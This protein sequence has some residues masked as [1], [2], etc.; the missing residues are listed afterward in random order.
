M[1]KRQ[2][3]TT[4]ARRRVLSASAWLL[5]PLVL[6]FVLSI[7]DGESSL[8]IS[9]RVTDRLMDDFR[10][11]DFERVIE[12]YGQL[13]EEKK[14]DPEVCYRLGYSYLCRN[15]FLKAEPFVQ[16]A[17]LAHCENI[18][19][20]P[21]PPELAER[22][23]RLKYFLPPLY[24][25]YRHDGL[26]FTVYG[27]PTDWIK[28][29][30]KEM[31]TFM[32]RSVRAFGRNAS[33]LDFYFFEKRD[34]YDRFASLLFQRKIPD[35]QQNG[36]G[37]IGVVLFCQEDGRGSPVAATNPQERRF[38]VLHEVGHALCHT[39]FGGAFLDHV[40]Q[41]LNEGVAD[42]LAGPFNDDLEERF[43]GVL[44]RSAGKGTPPTYYEMCNRLY[45]DPSVRYA[46]S[47]LM[48]LSVFK[49]QDLSAI[50][51]VILDARA[52]RGDFESAIRTVTGVSPHAAYHEVIDTFW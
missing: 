39:A 43:N 17:V 18:L 13:P 29:V 48:V 51:K 49:K 28:S 42:L 34:D 46:V 37:N 38:Y 22:I 8:A 32:R 33:N 40:P 44:R 1:E 21:P 11:W 23:R 50:G 14:N 26:E 3:L 5:C 45:E 16:A 4:H 15:Q 12:D 10:L 6:A 36:T 47:G 20:V 52:H 25:A 35:E 27:R 2:R 41:W 9:D 30:C 7:A 19:Y 24:K 31:P